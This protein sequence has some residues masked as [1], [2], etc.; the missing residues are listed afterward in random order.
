ME[1]VRRLQILAVQFR[2][3]YHSRFSKTTQGQLRACKRTER[4]EHS[5][6]SI[7]RSVIDQFGLNDFSFTDWQRA[8]VHESKDHGSDLMVAHFVFLIL[9]RD[10]PRNANGGHNC[11]FSK[12]LTLVMNH[13]NEPIAVRH[14]KYLPMSKFNET[15]PHT[16]ITTVVSPQAVFVSSHN[17][18]LSRK[19]CVT[20][21]L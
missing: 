9:P 1:M 3:R 19:R 8:L 12:V 11:Q 16:N 21:Q 10:F 18:P 14:N 2:T 4:T 5:R 6:C 7:C 20:R 17:A 15:Y 13:T